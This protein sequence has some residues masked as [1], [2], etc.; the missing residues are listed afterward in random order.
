LDFIKLFFSLKKQKQKMKKNKSNKKYK[1]MKI[2]KEW[3]LGKNRL[4]RVSNAWRN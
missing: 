1:K 4:K 3:L 2:K